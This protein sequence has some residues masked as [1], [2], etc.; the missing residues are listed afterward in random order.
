MANGEEASAKMALASPA[1]RMGTTEEIGKFMNFI[2]RDTFI[3]GVD[4]LY[5][6]GCIA[7]MFA[8]RN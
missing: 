6:G 7:N 2:L 5:D 3:T 8:V 1:G 4:Y